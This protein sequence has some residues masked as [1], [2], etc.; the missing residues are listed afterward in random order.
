MSKIYK[1]QMN[2]RLEEDKS[3]P[4]LMKLWRGAQG[5]KRTRL[6]VG[7]DSKDLIVLKDYKYLYKS[8]SFKWFYTA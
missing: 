3:L 5:G 2:D 6:I 1:Y 7:K 4:T 8:E